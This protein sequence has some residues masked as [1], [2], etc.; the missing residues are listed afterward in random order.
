MS[1]EFI[2]YRE[3]LLGR[4]ENA[5]TSALSTV[6]DVVLIG[7]I[8]AGLATKRVAVGAAGAGLG[9]VIAVVAHLF[10][11]GTVRDELTQ[12]ARHPVWAI[13]AETHRIFR[14]AA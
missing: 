4:H 8:A 6:G 12:V 10:Q 14:G 3:R 1:E 9:F 7:G 5:V 11:P 13:R 2:A